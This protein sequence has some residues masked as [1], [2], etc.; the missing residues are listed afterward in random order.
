VSFYGVSRDI[1]DRKHTER[2][3][4]RRVQ[5]RTR[6]MELVNRRLRLQIERRRNAEAAV[7]RLQRLDAIGQITSGIG[8]DFNNLL[9]VVLI[10]ARLLS[11]KVDDD[12]REVVD[13][14]CAAAERGAKLVAQL[15]AFSRNQRLEPHPVDLN[16]EIEDMRDL[17]SAT[18]GGNVHF[19]TRLEPNLWPA[20]VDPTQ[21][22]LI[23]LNLAINARDAMQS[24]GKLIIKTFNA[25]ID[26]APLQAGDPPAGDHVGLAV[27]DTGSG[28]ADDVLPRVFEPFFTTKELGKGSGLGLAQ[29]FGIAKQ[30]GG[31][32]NLKTRVGEGTSVSVYLPRAAAAAAV[33]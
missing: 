11:R 20:L 17:L 23:I 1:T 33:D 3:L 10:N 6:E 27:I 16:N 12:D 8:H 22:E 18:L 28:I 31:G 32:V 2:A 9:T 14:I 30:S 19:E 7:E 26:S 25:I 5:A 21:I 29:V 13:L 4:E 15:L 24:G